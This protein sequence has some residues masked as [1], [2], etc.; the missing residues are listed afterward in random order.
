MS[1]RLSDS[2][3]PGI[4]LPVFSKW[5]NEH[6]PGFGEVHGV[7]RLTGGRSNLSFVIETTTG[8]YVLR[9][10]PLGHVMQTAHDMSREFRVQR[11]LEE[12]SV[13][14]PKMFFYVP[15]DA[16]DNPL[17]CE[18]YLMELVSGTACDDKSFNRGIEASAAHTLSLQMGTVLADLHAVEPE[19]VGLGSFGR[20]G[21]FLRRQ[22]KRWNKQL[23]ASHS[24]DLPNAEKLG[25]SLLNSTPED[26]GFGI[27]HGD[28]KLN[29]TL[30]NFAE[31]GP[32]IAALLDWEMSTLGDPL[33]D[34]AVLGI[35]WRMSDLHPTTAEVFESPVERQAGYAEFGEVADAY[36][37][38]LRI[39]PPANLPWY[40]ALAAFKIAVIVES[41]HFRHISGLT[42]GDGFER[43]GEMTELLAAEGLRNL[44][45]LKT[46]EGDDL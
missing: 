18:F 14:V 33:T 6:H 27:V 16:E 15:A 25:D 29:N 43:M 5:L 35:Y 46:I 8:S 12:T 30:V 21:G 34:L 3:L 45:Q 11:A 40:N 24:R 41:L 38:R 19:S 10:P 44:K 7:R 26:G 4:D 1:Q 37:E 17:E 13:P 32:E 39:E 2:V 31:T 23:A 9:R 36:F 42:V 28:Y 22:V 20:R